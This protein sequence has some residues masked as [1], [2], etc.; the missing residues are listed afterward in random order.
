LGA[1]AGALIAGFVLQKYGRKITL[2][3]SSVL[4]FVAFLILATCK[5]HEVPAVMIAART[6]MGIAVGLSMPSATIYV[7]VL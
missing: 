6:L 3:L 7:S 1:I 4:T 2:L 5:I